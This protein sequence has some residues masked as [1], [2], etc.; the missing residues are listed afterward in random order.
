[1]VSKRTTVLSIRISKTDKQLLELIAKERGITVNELL[2]RIIDGY[3]KYKG[4][5][6]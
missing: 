4:L 1:M 3:L 2:R 5:K 6:V